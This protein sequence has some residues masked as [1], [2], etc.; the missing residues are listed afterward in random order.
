ML[1]INRK[2]E[3]ALMA[4]KFMANKD[5][6]ELT[7]AREICD[8]FNTPFDTTAKVMQAMNT[9]KILS[10]VKG[11]KGGYT[12]SKKLSEISYIDL[13]EIVD[14]GS[15]P[16]SCNAGSCN[17]GSCCNIQSPILQLNKKI[18]GFLRELTLEELLFGKIK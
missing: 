16:D 5:G 6:D 3:Y 17:L 2:V 8:K 18:T 11:V 9:S 7:S 10:S 15:A 14:K 1:K 13:C 4:L 12:L